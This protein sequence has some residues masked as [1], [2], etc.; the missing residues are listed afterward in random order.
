M[1]ISGS[2]TEQIDSPSINMLRIKEQAVITATTE[3]LSKD[4]K[5]VINIIHGTQSTLMGSVYKSIT[6]LWETDDNDPLYIAYLQKEELKVKKQNQ[7]NKINECKNEITNLKWR[8]DLIEGNAEPQYVS[9]KESKWRIVMMLSGLIFPIIGILCI[10][11][12]EVGL[13]LFFIITG[14]IEILGYLASSFE[15]KH[16]LREVEQAKKESEILPEL[17]TQLQNEEVKLEKLKEEYN[18]I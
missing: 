6:F 7:L 1:K 8:I 12:G 16:E 11:V 5:H 9:K 15:K 18:K 2:H 10:V 14:I 17:K 4:G 13:G 3:L